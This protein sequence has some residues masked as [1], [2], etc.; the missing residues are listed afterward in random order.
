MKGLFQE[1]RD[2]NPRHFIFVP[3][4]EIEEAKETGA[5]FDKKLSSWFGPPNLDRAIFKKWEH[6][7]TKKILSIEV[8]PVQEFKAFCDGHGLRF[9][10]APVMDGDFHR[11]PI[12]GDR[13]KKQ[14]A[15]YKAFLD[16]RPNGWIK[17]FKTGE[18]YKWVS[19]RTAQLSKSEQATQKARA[20]EQRRW[21]AQQQQAKYDKVATKAKWIWGKAREVRAGESAY[22]VHKCIQPHN[23]R[24]DS[25][26][27]LVV[28]MHNLRNEIRNLQFIHPD[29]E[30]IFQKGGQLK[31]LFCRLNGYHHSD[32]VILA[33]GF[34]TGASLNEITGHTVIVC[35]GASNLLT[36]AELFAEQR[37]INRNVQFVVAADNDWKNSLKERPCRN[38][39]IYYGKQA[40]DVLHCKM[41]CPPLSIDDKRENRTDF[42]DLHVAYGY[43]ECLKTLNTLGVVPH[44]QAHDS[45]T[46]LGEGD[47]HLTVS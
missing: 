28:P 17:N 1:V 38:S 9:Q 12:D 36:V 5:Q 27:N 3:Y 18:T 8:D 47:E 19:K 46:V 31:G 22:L 2:Q 30:K 11:V 10:G 7:R 25:Y 16:G 14:S 32:T 29:G 4:E 44:T 39:G 37:E 41:I 23:L 15:S 40:A 24:M 35:F 42:N 21:D 43:E 26:G 13:G 20:Y 33:E 34:A 6:P 45:F